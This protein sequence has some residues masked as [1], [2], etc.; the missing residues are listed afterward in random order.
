MSSLVG[1]VV[2]IS[3]IHLSSRVIRRFLVAA[4]AGCLAVILLCAPA[5]QAQVSASVSGRVTDPTGATVSGATVVA[6]NVETG[7]SRSTVTDGLGH[8][9]V[10]SLPV[11][12]YEMHV[13]KQGF[14]EQVRG[15]IHLVVGQEA[16]VDMGLKLGQ[17]TEQVKVMADAPIVSV[18]AASWVSS[19]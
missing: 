8:Y 11:G 18:A 7:E 17:V 14:Q 4:A 9:W 19:K 1:T 10:P 2:R 5:A 3:E 15:G 12:E 16:G 13:T 6:K